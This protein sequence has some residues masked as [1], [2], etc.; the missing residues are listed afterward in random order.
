MDMMAAWYT[1]SPPYVPAQSIEA[2]IDRVD[3][4]SIL[5]RVDGMPVHTDINRACMP[6]H[7]ATGLIWMRWPGSA[8]RDPA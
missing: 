3:L 6:K 2:I 4:G 8:Q 7:A 5:A 1:V